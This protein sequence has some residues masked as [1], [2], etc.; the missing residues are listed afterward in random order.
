MNSMGNTTASLRT[1]VGVDS[2]QRNLAWFF[3]GEYSWMN[4]YFLAVDASMETSNR[5][6][7][8]AKGALHMAGVSWAFFPR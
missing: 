1:S 8:E 2:K 7:K 3:S 6:G 4:R 5:F